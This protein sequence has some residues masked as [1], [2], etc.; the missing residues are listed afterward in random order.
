[1]GE[2]PY[3]FFIYWGK[4]VQRKNTGARG[5]QKES[6]QSSKAK[7]KNTLGY[8]LQPLPK[9]AFKVWLG[10]DANQANFFFEEGLPIGEIAGFVI[11]DESI[12]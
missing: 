4:Q 7:G 11:K 10:L 3:F 8:I 2:P 5:V 9:G 1:M 12:S 6:L